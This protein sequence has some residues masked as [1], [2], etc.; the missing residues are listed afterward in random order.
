M[1]ASGNDQ[2]RPSETKRAKNFS[3]LLNHVFRVS[4]QRRKRRAATRAAP[5]D[6]FMEFQDGDSPF[7]RRRSTVDVWR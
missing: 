2:S 1:A 7:R 6:D 3:P 4:V 5:T